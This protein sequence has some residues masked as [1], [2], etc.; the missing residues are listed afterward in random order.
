MTIKDVLNEAKRLAGAGGNKY[1][2]EDLMTLRN[3]GAKQASEQVT[4]QME[5]RAS[6]LI[7]GRSGIM[8]MHQGCTIEN[9]VVSSHEQ[10]FARDF[11]QHYVNT[12]DEN[13]GRGFIFSGDTG[14]GKNHLSAAIC[15]Q[16]MSQGKSCLIITISEL[17]MKMRQCYGKDP[18][19]AEDEFIRH[20]VRFDLLVLDEIGLQKGSDHEKLILNQVIDQRIGNIKPV[21]MLTN[22]NSNEVAEALGPRIMR[23]MKTNGG[24]WVPFNWASHG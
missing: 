4:K 10:V 11:S 13:F 1:S 5:N 22:L 12:F 7:T 23:R 3:D 19:Y 2:Y 17:M 24:Q 15:N 6:N 20:L 14:T 16:L 9:Y 18:E 8:P 21:G